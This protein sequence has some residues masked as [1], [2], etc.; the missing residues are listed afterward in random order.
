[1]DEILPG[2]NKSSDGVFDKNTPAVLIVDDN[3]MNISAMQG[4]LQAFNVPSEKAISG[5]DAISLIESR[6]MQCLMASTTVM[7]KLILLDFSMPEM[8][9]PEVYQKI[10]N[11]L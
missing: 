9:G 7:Y 10:K 11:T 3:I 6:I 4:E 8:D 1:M 2:D 5:T